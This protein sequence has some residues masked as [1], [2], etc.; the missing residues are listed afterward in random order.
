MYWDVLKVGSIAPRT[1]EVKF[2]DGLMGTVFIDYS[3]CTGVF[4]A[5]KNDQ[6][7]ALA[8]TENGVVTWPNG[9]DLAPDTMYWEIKNSP[10]H[11]YVI[12]LPT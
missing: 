6:T 5:L 8:F 7:V 10:I 9:L 11:R 2:S 12:R 3:F 4:E 1:L